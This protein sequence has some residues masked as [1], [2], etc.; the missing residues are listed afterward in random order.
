MFSPVP[1]CMQR[2]TSPSL[3][4]IITARGGSKVIPHKNI[5]PLGGKPLLAWTIEAARA[6]GAC[7]R[8]V[9]STDSADI[10]AVARRYGV[11]AIDR[12]A[13]ISHDAASVE[14]AL[15]HAL[16][17]VEREGRLPDAVL[18]LPPTSPFRKPE[19]ICAFIERFLALAPEEDA[20]FTL[21]EDRTDFWVREPDGSFRRRDPSAP[22]RRQ[23]RQPLY[24]ENSAMYCTRTT[25]LRE[26]GFILGR[27]PVGFI[28][29]A[30]EALDI[31][32]PR[33]LVYAELL[34]GVRAATYAP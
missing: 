7:G 15:L 34:V 14:S 1:P 32:E 12:P 24:A 25:A 33:D 13:T 11:E 19:T 17:V 16:E 10:V 4:T 5:V 21:H 18:T 20:L 30:D 2:T 31:N 6:A 22:R 26:T 27:H 9:V 23:D 29:N 8:I 28:I 3:L